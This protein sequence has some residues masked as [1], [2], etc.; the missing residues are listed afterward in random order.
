MPLGA[1]GPK[2]TSAS[3]L[4]G[5]S[6]G[7]QPPG[8]N[9]SE[10]F[11]LKIRRNPPPSKLYRILYLVEYPQPPESSTSRRPYA[12]SPHKIG[13]HSGAWTMSPRESP[14]SLQSLPTLALRTHAGPCCSNAATPMVPLH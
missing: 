13:S 14:Q 5:P 12:L 9:E 6:I 4:Y 8:K 7:V 3:Q 2:S 1:G 10:V 11:M